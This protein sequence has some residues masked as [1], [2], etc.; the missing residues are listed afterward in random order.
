MGLVK[1]A[2]DLMQRLPGLPSTPDFVLLD[3]RSP[4]RCPGLTSHH[5]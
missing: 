1:D 3:R 5:L 4:N 2:P